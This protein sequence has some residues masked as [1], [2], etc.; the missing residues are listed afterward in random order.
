MR[1]IDADLLKAGFEEDG[2]LSP[3]IEEYI[4]ACPT[5]ETNKT[6]KFTIS[7]LKRALVEVKRIC[8]GYKFCNGCP[9]KGNLCRLNDP[10]D[11]NIDD[12][13]EDSE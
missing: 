8:N 4:D 7:D 3:Y 1:T 10:Y 9:F 13:K 6:N 11:W 2:H 5:V 12:W